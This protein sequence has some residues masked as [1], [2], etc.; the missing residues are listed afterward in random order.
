MPISFVLSMAAGMATLI[1]AAAAVIKKDPPAGVLNPALGFSAGVMMA[2]SL[3]DLIPHAVSSLAIEMPGI[4]G[5]TACICACA[6]GMLAAR[7]LDLMVD[8]SNSG[9]SRLMRIGIFSMLALML[10]N[11]P[12][13]MAVYLSSQ[14]DIVLGAHLCAATALHNIPEGIAV[15]MPICA[16]TKSR[17]TAL[18]MAAVSGMA[19]PLGAAAAYYFIGEHPQ[20][21]TLAL[22]FS[23][24]AGLML[25][26]AV[27]ELLPEALSA[28]RREQGA[29]GVLM[30]IVVMVLGCCMAA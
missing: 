16:A 27:Y 25:A 8:T 3:T 5:I 17:I 26:T 30:G 11:I 22:I 20:E 10:H 7:L 12:E 1:G 4:A 19:E 2:M 29:S 9:R 24:I 28:K 14:H 21:R 6:A 18:M 13:G 15:A 23:A